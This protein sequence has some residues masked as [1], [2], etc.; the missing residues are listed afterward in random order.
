MYGIIITVYYIIIA[1]ECACS[2]V[3][4]KS[5]SVQLTKDE[6]SEA[7]G[8][9][10]QQQTQKMKPRHSNTTL[11]AGSLPPSKHAGPGLGLELGLKLGLG[12]GL[13]L[14]DTY[15]GCDSD[16]NDNST[17]QNYYS[18]TEVL[19]LRYS[20]TSMKVASHCTSHMAGRPPL[21]YNHM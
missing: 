21:N 7:Q 2:L 10:P 20:G 11:S 3:T 16:Q 13:G 6:H 18:G 1:H 15:N 5:Y 8:R 12:L 17:I 14:G 4:P 9:G 19:C